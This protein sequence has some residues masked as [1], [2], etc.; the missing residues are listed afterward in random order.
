MK[1]TA[2]DVS[3]LKVGA[4]INTSSGG[5]DAESEAEMLGILKSAGVTN[6]KALEHEG[7]VRSERYFGNDKVYVF[8]LP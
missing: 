4:I 8:I 2:L 1:S 3:G 5:C 7:F 6:C